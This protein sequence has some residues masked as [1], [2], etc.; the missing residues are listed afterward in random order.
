M[1]KQSKIL[2]VIN[3]C[4]TEEHIQITKNWISN[5]EYTYP[6]IVLNPIVI[7]AYEQKVIAIYNG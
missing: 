2:K 7:N 1:E 3:S 4:V 6:T 5:L